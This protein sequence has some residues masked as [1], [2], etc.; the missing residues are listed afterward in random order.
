MSEGETTMD[1][2][3][4]PTVTLCFENLTVLEYGEEGTELVPLSRLR[5]DSHIHGGLRFMIGGRMVPYTGY[6]GADDAC[7]GEWL[8]ELAGVMRSFEA[9]EN[10]RHVY[11]EGEQGQPAFVFERQG[12]AAFLSI[13]DSMVDGLADP[14]WQRVEFQFAD[15][16]EQYFAFR[17]RF[18]SELRRALSLTGCLALPYGAE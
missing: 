15:F 3:R 7:F 2:D 16:R 10:A 18:E 17:T 14:E 12:N 1:V 11:D 6:F 4:L 5:E 8:T 13:V 9:S